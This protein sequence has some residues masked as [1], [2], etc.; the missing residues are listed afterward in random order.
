MAATDTYRAGGRILEIARDDPRRTALVIDGEAWSYAELLAAARTIANAFP[1]QVDGQAQPVT[2]VMAQRHVSAYAGIL[3]A[4]LSGHAYVPLNVNHPPAR[5]AKILRRSGASRVICGELAG[6]ALQAVL[7]AGDRPPDSV[8]VVRCGDG[9]DDYDAAGTGGDWPA[10]RQDR[11]DDLAYILF[12]SGSTGEPKGVPIRNSELESYLAAAGPLVEPRP[13]DRFSQTFDLTFDLSVHDLFLSWEHGATLVVASERELRMPSAYIRRHGITCWF[14]VPSLAYQVRL[15]EDLGPGV[16]PDLRLSLF[17]GEALPAVVAREWA[18]A[19]PNSRVENWYGPTEATIA[20]SRYVLGDEAIDEDTVPIGTAFAGMQ[21]LVLG[22]DLAACAP[23]DPGELF[24]SGA[25]LAAGYLNDPGRTRASFL[26]LP[27]GK[28]AYRTG[29]RAVLGADGNVRFL[30]RV[31]NQVK[32]RGYRIELGEIEAALRSAAGGKNAVALAW[33]GGAEIATSVVAAL[34]C[35]TA[36]VAAIHA[37]LGRALPEYMVP[38]MIFCLSE[39]P[40]NAS[41]KVDRKALAGELLRLAKAD[42]DA[43]LAQLSGEARILLESILTHAPLLSRR[44]ILTAANLFDAGMDSLAFISVTT[45]IEHRFGL[46]LDQDTVIQLSEMS[47][48]DIV[49][50]ARGETRRLKAGQDGGERLTVLDRLKQLLRIPRVIRKPRANRALQFIERFPGYLADHGAPDVLAVGSSCTF[51]AF[52]PD[53]FERA[54][55]GFGRTIT[56]LNAGFPAVNVDGMRMMCEF[57]RDECRKAGVRVPLI[58]YEFDVMH[59]STTPPS[60]DI[61]L[62]PDFFSGNVLSLRGGRT[63]PEFEWIVATAGAWNAPDETR[64]K[65]RKPNWARQRD[66]VIAR[67]YLGDLEFDPSAAE[68]WFAGASALKEVADD[69]RLFLHPADREMLDELGDSFA[70]G[71][72]EAFTAELSQRLAAPMLPWRDFEL[73]PGHY[74]DINHMN[75]R[76]GRDELSRQLAAMIFASGT[77]GPAGNSA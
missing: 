31:D 7:D 35:P 55:S 22:A 67:A 58:I 70:T 4:R 41:G 47:F 12:T 13:D 15:Q 18:Q 44:A 73:Q 77:P 10:S 9:K 42:D 23:G 36:D 33:P 62:G 60:G 3:A 25:Q 57:I 17:C 66:R 1:S 40:K 63:N 27:D 49:R 51:R 68:T 37:Q 50:E 61:N 64:Q 20:C 76:G 52:H 59:V 28:R 6:Q 45:D 38:A 30:G 5:N 75:A 65:T 72:L 8:G 19:A 71:K 2:A 34:E 26:T 39:F 43:D 69:M 29:D 21:L 74:L 11:L 53:V 56:S 24:L 54:A 46:A 48:D 14:S 16:F 32:V